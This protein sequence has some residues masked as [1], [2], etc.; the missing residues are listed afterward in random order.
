MRTVPMDAEHQS[1]NVDLALARVD[2]YTIGI[3]GILGITYTGKYDDIASLDWRLSQYNKTAKLPVPIHI[4]AASGGFYAPFIEPELVWDFRLENV[5]SINASGH[6]YGLVYPGIGWLV[7]K[8]EEYMPE[9]L[10]F[11]VS[12]LGGEMP[13]MALNFS[14]SASQILAQYYNFVRL[15]REGYREIHEKTR[16]VAMFLTESV[17]RVGLFEIIND[18]TALPL[19]CY[20]LKEGVAVEWTLY[21]LADRLQMRGWQVPAYPLPA[22]LQDIVI[23]RY[24]IRA[25]FSMNMAVAFAEDFRQAID[26]LNKARILRPLEERRGA[27]GFTH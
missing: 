22:D 2:E 15:G 11:K 26:E 24:V 5:V 14:R 10:I 16:Q 9:E 4:D 1:L 25:D 19:V 21:D 27:H 20:R 8:D 23:Q 13:T 18:G 7:W 3:V 12:Y 6:K 17:N